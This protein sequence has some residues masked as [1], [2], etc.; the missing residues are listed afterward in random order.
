MDGGSLERPGE[1]RRIAAT[2]SWV[3]SE[4]LAEREN[5]EALEG[6]TLYE[7]APAHAIAFEKKF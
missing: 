7:D 1:Y 4:R 5:G 6:P 2:F 3:E